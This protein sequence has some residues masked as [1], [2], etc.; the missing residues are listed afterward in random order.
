[1]YLDDEKAFI[2]ELKKACDSP[3][4]FKRLCTADLRESELKLNQDDDLS[5]GTYS[6]HLDDLENSKL[7]LIA[8]DALLKNDKD[9]ENLADMLEKLVDDIESEDILKEPTN[10]PNDKE[11]TPSLAT[12]AKDVVNV[13]SESE[14]ANTSICSITE[15]ST[16]ELNNILED[17]N[18]IVD[19]MMKDLITNISD[20]EKQESSSENHEEDKPEVNE[21]L[22]DN[23]TEDITMKS[24]EKDMSD[25]P[26][27]EI[28]G[29]KLAEDNQNDK[30]AESPTP[31]EEIAIESNS[32]LKNEQIKEPHQQIKPFPLPYL[33]NYSK[34]F[35][36]LTF[37]ELEQVVVEKLAE[38]IVYRSDNSELRANQDKQEKIIESLQRRLSHLSKQYSDMEMIHSRV[39]KDMETR[40]EGIVTP[41]KITRAVG[42]QVFQ[43][44]SR[45]SSSFMPAVSPVASQKRPDEDEPTTTATSASTSA[46]TSTAS[47]I[48]E[49][50]PNGV[51]RK[52][53]HKVT[54]MRPPLT[55]KEKA[56]L[57]IQEQKEEQQIRINATKNAANKITKL[58]IP[59]N[60]TVTPIATKTIFV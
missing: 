49:S 11:T 59:A 50:P 29:E 36:K 2:D 24:D 56:N 35:G 25:D 6:K 46:S 17:D 42:L 58:V 32:E 52:T 51:K 54:P 13:D 14:N 27:I 12:E 8:E 31:K 30:N 40:N 10:L 45:K 44:L 20:E 26:V 39:L 60:I 18:D 21:V 53:I 34:A 57:E 5:I 9:S 47:S 33:H 22:H 7:D 1:M 4:P 15:A 3:P 55:D 19:C 38:I 43:P 41:V 16:T 37:E 48:P 28:D 23:E